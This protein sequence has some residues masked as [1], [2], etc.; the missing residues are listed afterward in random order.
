MQIR[1]AEK[2]ANVWISFRSLKKVDNNALI[3]DLNRIPWSILDTFSIDPD[4]MLNI[5]IKLVL[6]VV[7][8]H[9]P[10]EKKW[11]KSPDKPSWLA[12]ETQEVIKHRDHLK[13]LLDH[14]KFP[15]ATYNKART[16]VVHM[17]NKAKSVAI[18]NELERN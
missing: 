12:N 7:D 16:K 1:D 13:K 2:V 9:A 17:V 3:A 11:V 5:W 6:D 10:M 15:R 14:G 8:T 18:K 4:E